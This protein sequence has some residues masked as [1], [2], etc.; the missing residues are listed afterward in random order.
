MAHSRQCKQSHK[1]RCHFLISSS[2]DKRCCP[3]FWHS[4]CFFLAQLNKTDL[5]CTF[6]KVH[7]SED[8]YLIKNHF[9]V[10]DGE[11][12]EALNKVAYMMF[13]FFDKIAHNF[14]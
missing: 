7:I 2:D 8:L 10:E 6:I 9:V 3:C 14:G 13:I 4:Y 1:Q 12:E 5:L 11:F